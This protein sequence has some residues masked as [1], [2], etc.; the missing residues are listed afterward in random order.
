M[1]K[2]K[3]EKAARRPIIYNPTRTELTS[4]KGL[5]FVRYVIPSANRETRRRRGISNIDGF[6][7]EAIE[8]FLDHRYRTL[9]APTGAG[10]SRIQM[11]LAVKDA[12]AGFISVIAGP[13]HS[14]GTNFSE[15]LV[16]EFKPKGKRKRFVRENGKLVPLVETLVY[17]AEMKVGE[18]TAE[19]IVARILKG[20]RKVLSENLIV[21]THAMLVAVD[22]ILRERRPEN[23]WKGVS[24]TIDEAHHSLCSARENPNNKEELI[25]INNGIGRIV[26]QYIEKKPGPLLL[27]TATWFRSTL[28]EIVP[29]WARELFDPGRYV[30]HLDDHMASMRYLKRVHLNLIFA[31]NPYEAV[32]YCLS[33]DKAALQAHNHNHNLVYLPAP[34]SNFYKAY[35]TDGK[36]PTKF[37]VR[38]RLFQCLKV[39]NGVG[40]IEGEPVTVVDFIDDSNL[41]ERQEL[42]DQVREGISNSAKY[43]RKEI[44]LARLDQGRKAPNVLFSNNMFREGSDFPTLRQVILMA[45]RNSTLDMIQMLGRLLRDVPGKESVEFNVILP[46]F[47]KEIDETYLDYYLNMLLM[48]MTFDWQ[49]RRSEIL[50][51]NASEKVT[52]AVELVLETIPRSLLREGDSGVS[53][54]VDDVIRIAQEEAEKFFSSNPSYTETERRETKTALERFFSPSRVQDGKLLNGVSL[55]TRDPY[56]QIFDSFKAGLGCKTWSEVRTAIGKIGPRPEARYSKVYGVKKDPDKSKR[57]MLRMLDKWKLS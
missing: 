24:L 51:Y 53:R 45:P 19:E 39:E 43:F 33:K 47:G 3:S 44:S 25:L 36:K 29:S 16:F 41:M 40:L 32:L 54:G 55:L 5:K 18:T 38:D 14:V 2:K 11:A 22:K 52:R 10:K 4:E 37:D 28:D 35:G 8:K 12:M 42:A 6:Q 31:D 48:F 17:D 57:E 13:T 34:N 9:I 46:T 21:C 23:P 49:S 30:R 7:N 1:G 15:T 26:L 56:N 50:G 20:P 27:V